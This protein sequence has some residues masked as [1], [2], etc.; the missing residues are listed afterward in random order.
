MQIAL[1]LGAG[2]QRGDV[3]GIVESA[4]E[5]EDDVG[6]L[7]KLDHPGHLPLQEHRAALEPGHDLVG[8]GAGERHYK[9]GGVA[10]IRAEPHLDHGD[11]GLA[12]SGS[13]NAGA[14][15]LGQRMRSSSPT[16]NCRWEPAQAGCVLMVSP[17][18]NRPEINIRSDHRNRH[19]GARHRREPGIQEHRPLE[20]GFLVPP[21]GRPRNDQLVGGRRETIPG[22]YSVRATSSTSKHSMTSPC[23][24]FS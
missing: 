13:R 8:L 4:V 19:S 17:G 11:V 9:G 15:Q 23:W 7:P 3:G 24:M 12:P 22:G 20:Y 2:E 14:Q 16:R 18:V 6:D 5:R 10:Q 1:D 21:P